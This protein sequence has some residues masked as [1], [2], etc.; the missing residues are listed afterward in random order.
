M[1]LG[2]E[3]LGLTML[4]LGRGVKSLL[5]F[6]LKRNTAKLFCD[7]YVNNRAGITAIKIANYAVS[8]VCH[9][10]YHFA[11]N[12]DL[13]QPWALTIDV[14]VI[15]FVMSTAEKAGNYKTMPERSRLSDPAQRG[16]PQGGQTRKNRLHCEV[17]AGVRNPRKR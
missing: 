4:Q 15:G 3:L 2:I 7:K 6:Q 17:S 9:E 1:R 14:S 11:K 10:R 13:H 8:S 12:H 5:W 16:D